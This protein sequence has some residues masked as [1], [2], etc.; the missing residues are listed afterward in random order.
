MALSHR[1]L[2]A[3]GELKGKESDIKVA[4][5]LFQSAQV[6]LFKR[7]PLSAKAMGLNAHLCGLPWVRGPS[8][9]TPL[10]HTLASARSNRAPTRISALALFGA[11][12]AYT[13]GCKRAN[14]VVNPQS[15][16]YAC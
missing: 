13:T 11:R 7:R 2:A 4:P 14:R 15:L 9:R 3:E 6:A 16:N 8:L 5:P 1:E 10:T 12:F